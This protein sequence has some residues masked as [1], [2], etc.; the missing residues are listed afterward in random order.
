MYVKCTK[1]E[2]VFLKGTKWY[3]WSK[4][5]KFERTYFLNGSLTNMKRMLKC[6]Q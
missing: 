4:I 3:K 2:W 1:G 5:A 6:L